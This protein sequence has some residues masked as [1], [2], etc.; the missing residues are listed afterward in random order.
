ML[1]ISNVFV[2]FKR[3]CPVLL[4]V[5]LEIIIVFDLSKIVDDLDILQTL[6]YEMHNIV[7]RISSKKNDVAIN[8]TFCYCL[9]YLLDRYL[10]NIS[11][12]YTPVSFCHTCRLHNHI[13]LAICSTLV[14]LW[15]IPLSFSLV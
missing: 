1:V 12:T 2:L 15:L 4:T 8:S 10:L 14:S 7:T 3:F 13:F 5:L 6:K 9:T 11:V